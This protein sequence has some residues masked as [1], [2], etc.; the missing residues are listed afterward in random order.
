MVEGG[1]L[2]TGPFVVTTLERVFREEWGRVLATLIGFL[3]DFDVAE[4][5]AQ[6]AFAIAAD[7]WPRDGV[8]SNPRAW[9]M[10]TARNR[11]TDRI[12]RERALTA[13][14]G[15]LVTDDRAEAPVDTTTFPD[16][17]LELIF[18]CC[19]PAL[20]IEAQVAL[21]LRT[22]GGLTTDEI[23]RAFLVPERTM[24][25]RLV[26]AK[27]KI[28]AAGIPFRVPPAHLLPERL[29]AVLAVVYL[30]FNEGYGGRD[31]LAAEAIWLGRALAGLLAGQPEVHGLLAM[32]LLHDSRRG[33]RFRDGEL[34]LLGD[35]DRTLWDAGQIAAGRAS[36]D[37][38]LALGGRG[39]YV[40]QAAIASL[41][42][43]TPCDWAQ[44][45]AL[46]GRLA[47]LTGSPVVEL[48]RAIAVAESEGSEAGLGIVDRLGLADFR[49]LHS[50][51]AEL[52]RRLGRT[53]EAREALLRARRLTDDGAERRFL[54]RR[55]TE[56]ADRTEP[57]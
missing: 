6:E 41:H 23:A 27:R 45:A 7:R 3:G 54:E 50:T 10:T 36:L 13:R 51:R 2:T 57:G 21:T 44:I 47:Q 34:V 4:E 55:L 16:E 48:N 11:A 56:L 38:A 28:K 8:P 37:R 22:L 5:A 52:L 15:L 29:D 1:T 14:F 19:H 24:A 18:T 9:L 25:Q 39:P 33:A 42:A 20:A 46:Y 26:R 40:L 32:M 12:R 53:G 35:Q 30:I 31:E 49:Y 43:E 17:R